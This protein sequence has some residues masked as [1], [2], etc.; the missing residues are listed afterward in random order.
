M[1]SC[2]VINDAKLYNYKDLRLWPI[3]L[4]ISKYLN[5]CLCIIYYI[6]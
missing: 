3:T 1:I 4:E 6:R 5:R 2:L